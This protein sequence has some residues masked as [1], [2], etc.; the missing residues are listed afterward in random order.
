MASDERKTLKLQPDVGVEFDRQKARFDSRAGS[1]GPATQSEFV[2]A[3][4]DD[5]PIEV[6]VER[7][8]PIDDLRTIV[9]D[10]LDAFADRLID[11]L[12][13]QQ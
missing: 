2:A 11:R 12:R 4:L 13:N 1:D 10:E 3:L 7:S 6:E 9:R 5:D 8:A